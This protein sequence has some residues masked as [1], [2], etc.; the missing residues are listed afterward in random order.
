MGK[1]LIRVFISDASPKLGMREIGGSMEWERRRI[2][3]SR[4][5]ALTWFWLGS[6][7]TSFKITVLILYTSQGKIILLKINS[8][9]TPYNPT[10]DSKIIN[11]Q[12]CQPDVAQQIFCPIKRIFKL[13]SV[14]RQVH[15]LFQ[16]EF[17]TQC[18]L[19]LP[20]ST[21][22]IHSFL[23]G[24]LAAAC[25]FTQSNKNTIKKYV[26]HCRPESH[27]CLCLDSYIHFYYVYIAIYRMDHEKVARVR[28]IA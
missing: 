25:F 18:Y 27:M 22:S 23:Y 13:Y 15:S 14:F 3:V 26:R 20:L 5:V 7:Y 12:C 10:D 8:V 21:S 24:H 16:T 19:V 4:M 1:V 9:T 28:S 11:M 2:T 6:S 17:S